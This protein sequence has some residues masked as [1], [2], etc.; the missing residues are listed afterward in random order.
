MPSW[1]QSNGVA[2]GAVVVIILSLVFIIY[3]AVGGSGGGGRDE[4]WMTF[5]LICSEC[6]RCDLG[7]I[8]L[9]DKDSLTV[10][11]PV[12]YEHPDPDDDT[13]T[14][15][16]V[17][18]G[19]PPVYCEACQE[20]FPFVVEEYKEGDKPEM[21]SECEA[22]AENLIVLDNHEK[23]RNLELMEYFNV[24]E[25]YLDEEAPLEEFGDEPIE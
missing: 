3:Q 23:V 24:P 16:A 18:Q 14:C 11:F 9:E 2:I 19:Y 21:C 13:Q 17:D 6:W 7:Q 4:S 12:H 25:Y 5:P 8:K 10:K 1:S 22:G 20:V 15:P